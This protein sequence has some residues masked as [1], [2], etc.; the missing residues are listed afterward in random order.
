MKPK[1]TYRDGFNIGPMWGFMWAGEVYWG[2]GSLA[3]A[4]SSWRQVANEA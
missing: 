1:F 3:G 4:I 2:Y